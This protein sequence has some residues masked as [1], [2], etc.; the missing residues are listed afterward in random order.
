[1]GL[2]KSKE[3]LAIK[4][5]LSV[6]TITRLIRLPV[7]PDLKSIVETTGTNNLPEKWDDFLLVAMKNF[8]RRFNRGTYWKE[9]HYST[10]MGPN[11]QAMYT[12]Y[13]DLK[14]LPQELIDDLGVLG[15]SSVTRTIELIKSVPSEDDVSPLWIDFVLKKYPSKKDKGIIRRLAYLSDKEGKT[16]IVGL[17]D[18]WSQTVLKPL[19]DTINRILHKYPEDMTFRQNE[20][21]K[22]LPKGYYASY[23]LKNATDSFPVYLQ[24][25][26]LKHLIGNK[27]AEA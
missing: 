15:G 27:R 5:G 11:G 2:P 13:I 18:Y 3:T 9:F 24:E 6:L 17:C 14:Y 26:V 8:Q 12:S 21:A 1:M 23:D 20:P 16:R 4:A 7:E 22:H 19:H 10:K 25:S